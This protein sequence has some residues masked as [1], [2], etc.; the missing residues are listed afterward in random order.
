MLE[1]IR[2]ALLELPDDVLG[3]AIDGRCV[4]VFWLERSSKE[5]AGDVATGA[6]V[7]PLNVIHTT[8]SKIIES[9]KSHSWVE[10]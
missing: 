6:C 8:L 4:G 2:E 5:Q 7:E 1:S 3:I 9:I 10:D